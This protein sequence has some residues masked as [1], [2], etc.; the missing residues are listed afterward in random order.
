MELLIFAGLSLVGYKMSKHNQS[1][2]SSETMYDVSELQPP[3]EEIPMTHANMVPFYKSQKSQNTNDGF[4]DRRLATF[5]GVDN[6]EFSKKE[7]IY[8]PPP[9]YDQTNINGT[10]FQPDIDRYVNF[11][12]SNKHNN[13]SPVEKQ[14]VGP[15]LGSNNPN[16]G[17]HDTF[18]ILP[19]NVNVYRKNNL[20]GSMNHGKSSIDERAS[21]SGDH[22]ST[23]RKLIHNEYYNNANSFIPGMMHR[24][25]TL[26]PEPESSTYQCAPP[27]GPASHTNAPLVHSQ[28]FSSNRLNTSTCLNGN[29]HNQVNA[30]GA[31]PNFLI[32][33]NERDN[34]NCQ[35]LNT[36]LPTAS[37]QNRYETTDISTLR[38][39]ENC[40]RLNVNGNDYRTQ[41]NTFETTP[42]QRG[43]DCN[44]VVTHPSY[45]YGSVHSNAPTTNIATQRDTANCH[46][47][48]PH[49]SGH[50]NYTSAYSTDPH[51]SREY[52][53]LT[54]RSPI[55]GRM[56]V[57]LDNKHLGLDM[58]QD[59]NTTSQLIGGI[60][61]RDANNFTSNEGKNMYRTTKATEYENNRSF[62]YI[63]DNPLSIRIN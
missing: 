36:Q 21:S 31:T 45:T 47:T 16:P 26:L 41:Q 48:H 20:V 30:H 6:L 27:T 12:A 61:V 19:D 59:E 52:T 11:L 42:T 23:A 38:D 13:I 44:T 24:S 33:H 17:F 62:G 4:K 5:T 34:T 3:V 63:Q 46:Q 15:G 32:H 40:H 43:V 56:N 39:S 58:K 29:P 14:H 1:S 53:V 9:E 51:S 57:P 2:L 28:H 22:T 60:F 7:E 25:T 49:V 8:Q 18:R 37:I 10:T 35:I 54:E 50:T 55:A